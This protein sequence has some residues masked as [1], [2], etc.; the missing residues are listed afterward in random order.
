MSIGKVA[1]LSE[2]EVQLA[3]QITGKTTGLT[4][5]WEYW[6]M[7]VTKAGGRVMGFTPGASSHAYITCAKPDGF[8]SANIALKDIAKLFYIVR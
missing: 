5:S 2:G 3:D 4:R 8:F 7:R 6:S 1:S